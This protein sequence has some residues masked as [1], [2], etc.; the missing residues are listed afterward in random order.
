[1]QTGFPDAIANDAAALDFSKVISLDGAKASECGFDSP[2]ATVLVT[3]TDNTKAKI[4][5]G[6]DAPSSAG[7]Y[8][9]FGTSDTIY[10][11]GSDA[12]DSFSYSLTDMFSKAINDAASN[13]DNSQY[14]KIT[15][16]GKNF[17]QSVV[18]EPNNDGKNSATTV[19][20]SPKKTYANEDAS[21]KVSG[22]IR[23]LFAESV[24]MVNP[25]D[26]QLKELGLSD[27]Y[28]AIEAVYPDTTV[29][30]IASKPDSSGK[31][32]IMPKGGKVVYTMASANLPWVDMS[33]E[34]LTSEYVLHPL[35]SAVST[36][37]INNGSNTYTF[38]I[39]TKETTTTN[40]DGEESTSTTTT[41]VYKDNELNS[42]YFS[43][44]FQ[45]L[46]LLT[47]SDTTSCHSANSD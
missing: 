37:T 23:G 3:Y 32:N 39:S 8:V 33:Y 31:V 4:I 26:A 46:T 21:S 38:D 45:N 6:G 12:V 15:L 44:F 30:L 2:K 29:S 13:T 40:E 10:L 18:L 47:K 25:S 36:L 16:S 28:A 35:M 20:T 19:I 24:K 43:T 9:K 14:S 7:T 41:V 22:A 5:V 17:P 34:K 27:P 11:V 42:S 1:M